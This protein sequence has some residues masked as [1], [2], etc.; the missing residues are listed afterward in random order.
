MFAIVVKVHMS[1]S[2]MPSPLSNKPPLKT[3][4]CSENSRSIRLGGRPEGMFGERLPDLLGYLLL[5][6]LRPSRHLRVT[7]GV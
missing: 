2:G 3:N 1:I 4:I 6:H 5:V 7:L